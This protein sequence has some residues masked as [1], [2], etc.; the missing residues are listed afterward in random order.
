M[1]PAEYVANALCTEADPDHGVMLTPDKKRL[2]HAAM[3][4]AT[5][6]GEFVD[7]L[8]KHIFYGKPLDVVNLKEELGDH[9]WYV[10]I[11]CDVLDVTLDDVMTRNIEK[12]RQRYP[13]KF[14]S[15]AALNRDLPAERKILES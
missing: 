10:A 13:G 1:T 12:L 6:A 3:G 9:L 4:M 15:D 14:T 8:K 7:A 5:E 11:A 2:L